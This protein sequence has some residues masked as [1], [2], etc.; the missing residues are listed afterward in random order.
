[1][2]A[3][4][5]EAE[6]A[7]EIVRLAGVMFESMDMN[8]SDE[9]WEDAGMV[10]RPRIDASLDGRSED[11]ERVEYD[12]LVHALNERF[13]NLGLTTRLSIPGDEREVCH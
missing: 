1:M 11:L 13:S 7:T 6:D 3:R 5:A 10:E 4:P 12:M 9:E 8:L 2:K